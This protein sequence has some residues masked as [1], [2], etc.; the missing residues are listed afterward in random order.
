VLPVVLV[1]AAATYYL[2]TVPTAGN[3]IAVD[4]TLA[5]VGAILGVACALTTRMRRGAD[6]VCCPGWAWWPRSCGIV[7]IGARLGFAL[8]FSHGGRPSRGSPSPTTSPARPPRWPSWS[9]M[10]LAEVVA[11]IVTL[12]V[13]ALRL[14]AAQVGPRASAAMIRA[15]LE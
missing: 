9:R 1:G 12:R 3:D 7:G 2:H 5:A 13:R 8:Y 4:L 10:A 15:A 11:R 6:A 14:P